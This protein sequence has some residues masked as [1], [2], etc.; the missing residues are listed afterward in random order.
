[1]RDGVLSHG[2]FGS[3]QWRLSYC[4]VKF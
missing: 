1:L 4:R 3:W 2:V